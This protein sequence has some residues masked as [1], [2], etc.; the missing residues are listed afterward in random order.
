MFTQSV[1][2]N[3]RNNLKSNGLKGVGLFLGNTESPMNYAANTYKF[4]QDSTFLYFFGLNLSN[5]AGVIDFDSGEEYIFGDDVE[6]DDI[7]WMGP[8]PTMKELAGQVGVNKV[9]PFSNLY[10]YI[11]NQ[12]NLKREIHFLPTYRAEN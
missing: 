9:L 1:Y 7:I 4:R 12:L 8:Q 6:I 3:R 11:S 2:I 10:E 5:L